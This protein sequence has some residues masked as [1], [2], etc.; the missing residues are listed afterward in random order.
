MSRI[1]NIMVAVAFTPHTQEL[2]NYAAELAENLN[3]RLTAV[4]VLNIKDVDHVSDIRSMGYNVNEEDYIKGIEE[5]RKNLLQRIV[6]DSTFPKDRVETV[7][8]VGHPF[9]ELMSVMKENKVDMI[10]MGTKG[11]SYLHTLLVG[12]VA[13]QMFRHSP[14]TIVSY[15]KEG[16][17]KL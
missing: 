2:F 11:H 13:E 12:S 10:V 14:V 8:R 9:E 1:S 17:N 16:H 5:E 4:N 7:F 3:A 6:E 15:R